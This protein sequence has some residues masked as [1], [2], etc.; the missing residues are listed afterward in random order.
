MKIGILTHYNVNNQGAQLQLYALSSYLKELGHDV[1]VLTYT[2]NFDYSADE[3]KRNNVSIRSLPFYIKEY[4]F[5]RGFGLSLFNAR[6]YRKLMRFLNS[7]NELRPYDKFPTDAVVIGS[8]EVFSLDVGMNKMMY[9]I[10]LMSNYAICYAP[11]FGIT[12]IEDI[13]RRGCRE[14]ISAGLRSIYRLSARDAH[15]KELV[16]L[17]SG[18][19]APLVC[20]PVLLY[21]FK[22][23]R[24]KIKPIK[25]KYLL[26]YAYDRNMCGQSEVDAIQAY[27]RKHGLIT[28]SA[29]TYHKWCDRNVCCN[30]LEWVEYIRGAECVVTD[31]FHGTVVAMKTHR[32]V[33]VFIR[34]S[35][36]AFKLKSLLADTAAEDREMMGVTY[37]EL[38][39]VFSASMDYGIIDAHIANIAQRSAAYL[40]EA[41]EG[42]NGE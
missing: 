24:A 23:E 26:L 9:G 29:G 6:K 10:G 8:D 1:Y 19:E 42:V 41:L 11:S 34:K 12:S 20:D 5:K 30:A 16:E 3:A 7:S 39:R 21:S 28:V 4:L 40:R 17:L 27:A 36:N 37:D 18:R 15:T 13:E 31:T 25:H 22:G 33:A 14:E 2:K 32:D 35:I 38:E